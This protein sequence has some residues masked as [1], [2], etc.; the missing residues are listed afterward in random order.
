MNLHCI[1]A[2]QRGQDLVKRK[3]E[4]GSLDHERTWKRGCTIKTPKCNPLILLVCICVWIYLYICST[5]IN[6]YSNQSTHS[7]P[8]PRSWLKLGIY[9]MVE[10]SANVSDNQERSV[11]VCYDMSMREVAIT[12][13]RVTQTKTVCISDVRMGT[14]IFCLGSLRT[15]ITR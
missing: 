6:N 5:D 3:S 11:T 4:G 7:C 8:M 1:Y 10:V 13:I 12:L 9:A 2:V 15:H 14:T